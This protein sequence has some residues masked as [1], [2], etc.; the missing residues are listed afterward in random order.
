MFKKTQVS[1]SD[2]ALGLP[3]KAC[4]LYKGF[5]VGVLVCRIKGLVVL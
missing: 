1:V 3:W 2:K 5:T 4:A